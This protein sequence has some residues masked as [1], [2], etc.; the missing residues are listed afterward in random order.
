MKKLVV[1]LGGNALLRK[2]EKGTLEEQFT[3]ARVTAR[4]IVDLVT[5]GYR[6][7][8][9]HGN[10]PQVGNIYLQ[11]EIAFDKVP[12]MSLD[13]CG[14]MSQGLIGFILTISLLNELNKRGLTEYSV[15]T[16][17]THV[18]VSIDDPAFHEPTKPIGPFYTEKE[19]LRL[20]KEKKWSMKKDPRGGWRRVV[21]SPAPIK[22][23]EAPIVNYLVEREKT[24]V[25]ACGGGGIPIVFREGE[26]RGV[27][28]VIDKDLTAAK[29]AIDIGAD[30]LLIL[31][32][33]E[34]VALYFGTP[35]QIWLDKMTVDE[36]EMYIEE[37]H[38]A[39]GS[40]LPKVLAA[41]NFVK[42][43]GEKAIIAK[44]GKAIEALAGKTGTCIFRA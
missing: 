11:Q 25:I 18:L 30:I 21:P 9:T 10:G 41:V 35:K 16:V 29:L 33:V 23:L 4:E 22:I 6:V 42:N 28:A 2:G 31:T 5:R 14:A 24:V 36:A 27:E 13:A 32:D 39:P 3:N 20:I 38:F 7:V 15:V 44:L 43:G 34:K 37:G 17:L 26:Y 12:P 40:M 8:I 1:A 19:A